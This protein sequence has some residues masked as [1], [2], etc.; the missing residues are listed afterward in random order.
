MNVL[1]DDAIF[2]TYAIYNLINASVRVVRL[3]S[4]MSGDGGDRVGVR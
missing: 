4:L 2:I 1:I 3:R